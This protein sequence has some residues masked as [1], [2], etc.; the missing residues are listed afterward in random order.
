MGTVVGE[1]EGDPFLES[2]LEQR[3]TA[4]IDISSKKFSKRRDS[5]AAITIT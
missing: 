2:Q 3:T 5:V 1:Y 4:R